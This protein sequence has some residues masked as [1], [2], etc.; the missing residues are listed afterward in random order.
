MADMPQQVCAVCR[1][2]SPVCLHRKPRF[3]KRLRGDPKS[4]QQSCGEPIFG[5]IEGQHRDPNVLLGDSTAM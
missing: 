5:M 2:S 4:G 3:E 1:R